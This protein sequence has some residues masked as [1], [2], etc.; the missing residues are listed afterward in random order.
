MNTNAVRWAGFF[1]AAML[2]T[3]CG[4]A[5]H[6]ARPVVEQPDLNQALERAPV[7]KAESLGELARGVNVRERWPRAQPGRQVMGPAANQFQ[8]IWLWTTR[9]PTSRAGCCLP[10]TWSPYSGLIAEVA[11]GRL[12]GLTSDPEHRDRSILHGVDAARFAYSFALCCQSS[13]MSLA[14]AASLASGASTR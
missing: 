8:G 5:A 2:T 10:V 7:L 3:A 13:S 1:T 14:A 12:L 11:P 6:V 9:T 4:S